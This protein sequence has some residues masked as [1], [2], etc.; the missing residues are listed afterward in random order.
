[1]EHRKGRKSAP[2][3]LSEHNSRY[4]Y[5]INPVLEMLRAHPD[6]IETLLI[7]Q[8]EVPPKAAGEILSRAQ[9]E[10]IR[11][12]RVPHQKLAELSNSGSH[13]GVVAETM[14]FEY[15]ELEDLLDAAK[16]S[17]RPALIVVL[18]GIQDP[19]NLGAI[20]R[21]AHALGAH[22][23]VIPKDRAVGVTGVVAKASAGALAHCPV[24]RVVNLSRALEELKEAGLWVA[25]ADPEG[26][27]SLPSARL[28]GALALVIGAE[29]AG[30]REGVLKHCDFRLQI[31]MVGKIGSLNASVSAGVM[32]YEVLRQRAK[33]A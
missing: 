33:G 4:I 20:V 28:D 6:R 14:T 23:V 7:A 21:S 24:A 29:G 13:Q 9:S 8:A 5:G 32:L 22:G 1:M 15:A 26:K 30:V 18:D 10:R 25:A 16:K 2:S 19:Q 27:D 12:V 3:E 17:G 31:P 11:V